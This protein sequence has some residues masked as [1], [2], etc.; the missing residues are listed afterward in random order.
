M[1][2]VLAAGS[3]SARSPSVEVE[4]LMGQ[5]A[6]LK[7]DGQ[8]K[9]LRVGESHQGVTLLSAESSSVTLDIDGRRE[10][11]GLSKRIVSN[12]QEPTEQQVSIP[13]NGNNQYETTATINGRTARVLIDTGANIVAMSAAHARSLGIDTSKAKPGHV[14]TASGVTEARGVNL[15]SVSVGGIRVNNVQA[16][17]VDGDFPATILLGMSYLRH[18]RMSENNGV[19]S[20]S[21]VQ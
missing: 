9:M 15:R 13:R 11:L 10:T 7:I 2:W 19:L 21:R 8:R 3:V 6:V 16:T 5:S 4:A 14:Q 18:V 1:F 20:L 17:V 12:Y